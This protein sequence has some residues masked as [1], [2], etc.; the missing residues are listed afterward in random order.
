MCFVLDA[1][2]SVRDDWSILLY[3]VVDVVKRINVGPEGTHIGVVTFGDNGKLIFDFNEFNKTSDYEMMISNE[4]AS[5]R[6][7]L[8]GERTFIN[9][10]LRLANRR[11]LREEFGM[12][13]DAMKVIFVSLSP[14]VSLSLSLSFS[15]YVSTYNFFFQAALLITDGRQTRISNPNE[16]RPEQV[17]MAMRTRGIRIY[18]IGIGAA[19]PVELWTYSSSPADTLFIRD[20]SELSKF[21]LETRKML[22]GPGKL[23]CYSS[24]VKA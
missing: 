22:L 11:V 20:F 21:T 4:I 1:S 8:S 19:D 12:R 23:T 15:L 14:S 17:S 10:G 5:I 13:P 18:A 24:E 16:P 3:F 7:P 9:R 2:G 6:K